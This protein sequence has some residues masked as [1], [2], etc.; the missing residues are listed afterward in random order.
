RE[1]IAAQIAHICAEH[2]L[3]VVDDTGLL[4]ENAGL[5]EWPT[6]FLSNFDDAFL[7]VPRE[8]LVTSL[9]SHQK[10]FSVRTGAA[11]DAPL[12]NAF[13]MVCNIVPADGGSTVIAGNERV[14]RARLSDAKFFWDQDRKTP[15]KELAKGLKNVTFHAK[16]GSVADRT[17]RITALAESLAPRVDAAA[18][19]VTLAAQLCKA[20]LV[21]GMVGEFPELQGIMGRYYA[22][23]QG[24]PDPVAQA[25]GSHY[26]PQGP[27]DDCPQAP[28]S[29]AL[30]LADKLELLTSMWSV[31][32]KPT[33]SKDPYALRRAALGVVRIVLENRLRIPLRSIPGLD[34]DLMAFFADR[35]KVHLRE[36]GARHDLIDAVFAL[37]G[38][39]DL[40][41]IMMRVDALA[42]FLA[43]ENGEALLAGTKR[44]ANIL[45]KEEKNADGRFDGAIDPQLFCQDEERELAGVIA[46]AG[47]QAED[48]IARED[49]SGAMAA[50]AKLR[51]PVDQFFDAV[52][53]NADDP[54]VRTNRLNLLNQ[55]RV[56]T[57]AVADFSKI[58]G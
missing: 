6:V 8:A 36:Q 26:R 42:S 1:K 19:D 34:D 15:L 49:F 21:S 3:S 55:I 50:L 22:L 29:M 46:T 56:A 30:A 37:P 28:V 18:A 16:L 57:R 10:V 39:D 12:A 17:A 47:K 32:E 9:R 38:Q 43:S 48:A 24:L 40:T 45:R 51:G 35:L 14:I 13:L 25:I 4:D 53:V 11:A 31:D 5:N 33:G 23:D 54:A 44:A 7:S 41:S 27:S 52:T 2:D 20:D 58:V